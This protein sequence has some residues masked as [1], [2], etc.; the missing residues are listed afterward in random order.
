VGPGV[1]LSTSQPLTTSTDDSRLRILDLLS[2]QVTPELGGQGVVIFEHNDMASSKR[3][4][5]SAGGR[6][7]Y[8]FSEHVKLL[9]EL[10]FDTTKPD[11]GDRATLTKLTIAPTIAA[12][13]GFWGRPEI[14]LFGTFA[15]W[16]DNAAAAGVDSEG[17]YTGSD[18]TSGATFGIHADGWW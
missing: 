7:G 1:D 3:D 10:G 17:L 11:G 14:R 16:N 15:F 9:A 5:I 18:K 2:F 4:W 12:G 8:A 6:V 13:R